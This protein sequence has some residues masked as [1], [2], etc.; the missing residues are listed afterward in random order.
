L[1]RRLVGISCAATT[2]SAKPRCAALSASA[3]ATAGDLLLGDPSWRRGRWRLDW[4][5]TSATLPRHP[6]SPKCPSLRHP[7]GLDCIASPPCAGL[8]YP[9][10]RR[11]AGPV[12]ASPR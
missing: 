6:A 4:D 5:G 12:C 8:G 1:L 11:L 2:A 10:L 7:V 3:S 9:S